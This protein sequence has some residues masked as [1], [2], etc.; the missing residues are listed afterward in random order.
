MSDPASRKRRANFQC[1]SLVSFAVLSLVAGSDADEQPHSTREMLELLP[2]SNGSDNA[3]AIG[4]SADGRP[5]IAWGHKAGGES[6][7]YLLQ[8]TAKGWLE[9]GGSAAGRGLSNTEG[10]ALAPSVQ[11]DAEAHPV[12]AWQDL[13]NGN[14]EIYLKRWNGTVWE[15]IERSASGGGISQTLSGLSVNPALAITK[16]GNPVIAWEERF[17]ANSDVY[18]RRLNTTLGTMKWEDVGRKA[19]LHGGMGGKVGRSAFPSLILDEGDRPVLTWQ[20]SLSGSFEILAQRWDGSRWKKLGDSV[21]GPRNAIA[22]SLAL[23]KSGEPLISWQ[24]QLPGDRSAIK[25]AKWNGKQWSALG[26][27]IADG[28]LPSLV[29]DG[30]GTAVIAFESGPRGHA[31]IYLRQWTGNAWVVRPG[32]PEGL[33]VQQDA[34]AHA[35]RIAAARDG[36]CMTWA[37]TRGRQT[38]IAVSCRN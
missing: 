12:V 4:V 14:Y 26:A 6:C 9:L 3:P 34:S 28:M 11:I 19:G 27:T 13:S 38:Q 32:T 22:P 33:I 37:E 20:D 8:R 16:K 29:V 36:I 23:D 30:N 31:R 5:I 15:E 18:I 21:S 17:G 24:E 7:I 2:A 1:L 25:A 35:V 10:T